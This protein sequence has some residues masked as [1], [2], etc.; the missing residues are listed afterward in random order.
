MR[1]FHQFSGN[2]ADNF[3][4][5]F[6]NSVNLILI[7]PNRNKKIMVS[8]I[9]SSVKLKVIWTERYYTYTYCI[10]SEVWVRRPVKKTNAWVM[11]SYRNFR[12]PRQIQV[13]IESYTQRLYDV[14]FLI[15]EISKNFLVSEKFYMACISVS[16]YSCHI[17]FCSSLSEG[18]CSEFVSR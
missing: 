5:R 6:I 18:A 14:S 1:I 3:M 8:K 9:L 12:T 7:Y 13:F 15:I 4:N 17:G 2:I 16:L 11:Q 10:V